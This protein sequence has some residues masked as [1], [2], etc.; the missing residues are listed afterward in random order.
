M[1]HFNNF[2]ATSASGRPAVL[3]NETIVIFQGDVGI[4]LG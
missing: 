2:V 3:E 4:Y 1:E